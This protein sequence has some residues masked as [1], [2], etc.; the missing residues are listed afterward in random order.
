MSFMS[1]NFT[2]VCVSE[3]KGKEVRKKEKRKVK[4]WETAEVRKRRREE[5]RKWEKEE[6]IKY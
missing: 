3:G 6:L 5:V 4:K 1:Q 2:R